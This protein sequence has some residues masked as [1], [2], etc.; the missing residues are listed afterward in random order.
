MDDVRLSP[1]I[2]FV[3]RYRIAPGRADEWRA[4]IREL[5]EFVAANLPDVLAFDA[6][7]GEDG[8]E[9]TSI[10]LHRDAASFERYLEAAASR[11]GN[12]TRIVDVARIDIYGKP[13]PSVVQRLRAMGT[14]PVVIHEH[15]NGF[16]RAPGR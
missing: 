4:A 1:G 8:T 7:L 6:Y 14:W 11:I 10:H 5:T 3:G 16:G 15:V 9:G 2:I 12:G 13:S